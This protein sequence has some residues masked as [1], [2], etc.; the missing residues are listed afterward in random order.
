MSTFRRFK[1]RQK[2]PNQK[3]FPRKLFLPRKDFNTK[4]FNE[5]GSKR[6]FS[7]QLTK[8]NPKWGKQKNKKQNESSVNLIWTKHFSLFPSRKPSPN[9]RLHKVQFTNGS[10]LYS[11]VI[12]FRLFA[13]VDFFLMLPKP[14]SITATKSTKM[15]TKQNKKRK[16]RTRN[17][18]K[19]W[20]INFSSGISSLNSPRDQKRGTL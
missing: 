15:N 8:W 17:E 7:M 16:T 1:S 3:C 9:I 6:S 20:E 11:S 18:H 5:T 2:I 13:L 10:C 12:F 4:L 14:L 19:K